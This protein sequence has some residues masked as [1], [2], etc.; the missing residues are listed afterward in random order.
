MIRLDDIARLKAQAKRPLALFGGAQAAQQALDSGHVDE[1]RLIRYLVLLGGGTLMFA[2]DGT[3]RAMT[4]IETDH[5]VGGTTV[6]R[7]AVERA[8]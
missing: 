7:Y 2:A 4:L 6:S 8:A 1:L 5:H 3:R